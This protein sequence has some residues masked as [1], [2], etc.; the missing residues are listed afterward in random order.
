MASRYGVTAAQVRAVSGIG[1]NFIDDTDM[2]Q[3]IDSAE[4][5]VDRLLNTKFIPTTTMEL[6]NGDNSERI[7]LK[8]NPVLKVRALEI[9]TTSVDLDDIRTD[10]S[11]GI[12]W[13]EATSDQT[14]F[15]TKNGYRQLTK[16]KYDYGWMDE[17][18]TQTT[19]SADAEAGSSVAL[20]VGDETGFSVGDYVK[21]EGFDG[22]REVAKVTATGSDEITVDSLSTDHESG[23]LV[24][25]VITPLLVIRLI[26]IVAGMM[27]VARVV[28]Q[29]YDEVTGYTAGEISVQKGEPYTQWREVTVQLQKEYK[30]ILSSLRARPA[31]R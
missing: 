18:S 6:L 27:G 2:G 14:S 5:E 12:V 11:A 9:D 23:S 16:I 3:L 22:L 19:T 21:I 26:Q 24:T 15:T 4:Y 28:G 20:S 25:K 1:S 29:S 31:V 13:L 10:M 8:Y 7:M 30:Q 17:T